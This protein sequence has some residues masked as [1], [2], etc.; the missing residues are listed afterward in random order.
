MGGCPY[1]GSRHTVVVSKVTGGIGNIIVR[2]NLVVFDDDEP[3]ADLLIDIDILAGVIEAVDG[4]SSD[5]TTPAE[6]AAEVAR[7]YYE[8]ALEDVA[9]TARRSCTP[10]TPSEQKDAT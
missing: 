9:D 4:I 5:D 8:L 6:K 1:C 7:L 3:C 10:A 2:D